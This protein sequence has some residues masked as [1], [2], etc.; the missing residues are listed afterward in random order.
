MELHFTFNN[1]QNYYRA[2]SGIFS[3]FSY[4]V[5]INYQFKNFALN[6]IELKHVIFRN[7]KPVP[8]CI[9]RYLYQS[10]KKCT[11]LPEYK[12]LRPLLILNDL[13]KDI[14]NFIF[15]IF[16]SKEIEQ[17]LDDITYKFIKNKI[18]LSSDEELLISSNIKLLVKDFGPNDTEQNPKEFLLFLIKFLKKN[19]DYLSGKVG[20]PYKSKLT[21]EEFKSVNFLDKKLVDLVNKGNIKINYV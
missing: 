5:G 20:K 14:S 7:N 19:N 8:G 1:Y 9:M 11:I 13:N 10:D 15:K 17:Q 16:N 18:I 6:N 4:D 21:E 2:N 3:Y 12:D